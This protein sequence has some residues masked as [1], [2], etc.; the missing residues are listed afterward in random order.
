MKSVDVRAERLTDALLAL[1]ARGDDVP[2]APDF[3][4]AAL[5]ASAGSNVLL[6][7]RVERTRAVIDAVRY[8]LECASL[9]ELDDATAFRT[10][11]LLDAFERQA[12]D[13]SIRRFIALNDH[14]PK[15]RSPGWYRGRIQ[16]PHIGGSE[17]AAV[18]G[19]S[20]YKT[21]RDIVMDKATAVLPPHLALVDDCAADSLGGQNTADSLGGQNT[22]DSLGGQNA[23][24]EPAPPPKSF[25][26]IACHWGSMFESVIEEYVA[27]E[28]GTP[29]YATDLGSVPGLADHRYSADGVGLFLFWE[30]DAAIELAAPGATP[31]SPPPFPGARLALRCALL[32]FK[33]P[34]QRFPKGYVPEHYEPQVLMGLHTV[35]PAEVGLFVEAVYRKCEFDQLGFGPEIDRAYHGRAGLARWPGALAYGVFAVWAPPP[36]ALDPASRAV[37]ARI[38]YDVHGYP[39]ASDDEAADADGLYDAAERHEAAARRIDAAGREYQELVRAYGPVDLGEAYF[40]NFGSRNDGGI[41][42]LIDAGVCVARSTR[43]VRPGD[44]PL[45]LDELWA[46]L[47]APPRAAGG[48]DAMSTPL[49]PLE[50]LVPYGVIP[51]KLMEIA[52]HPMLPDLEFVLEAGREIKATIKLVH[53]CRAEPDAAAAVER[54]FDTTC[55]G[56]A[57]G[58]LSGEWRP[59]REFRPPLSLAGLAASAGVDDAAAA[60]TIGAAAAADNGDGSD[61]E[62]FAA[63]DVDAFVAEYGAALVQ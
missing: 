38:V 24:S 34:Y 25:G 5:Y 50:T 1:A 27:L 45:T 4:T 40:S 13:A 6:R 42:A 63:F 26:G 12:M 20:R 14:L 46:P 23:Q 49:H 28:H 29:V 37:L 39:S 22:A 21:R 60:S 10:L 55:A 18:M 15:Q 8:Y 52:Y 44:A 3:N 51:W 59:A 57:P 30:S 61:D 9:G 54:Y 16:E 2:S 41:M 62:A 33:C 32:E 43:S 53:E 36:D 58:S 35:V 19:R 47:E 11:A 56:A 7:V 48:A 31:D 17:V